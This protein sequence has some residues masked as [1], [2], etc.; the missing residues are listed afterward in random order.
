MED[1]EKEFKQL[2]EEKENNF[3]IAKAKFLLTSLIKI[4]KMKIGYIL[5]ETIIQVIGYVILYHFFGLWVVIGIYFTI[6][7]NNLYLIRRLNKKEFNWWKEIW[8]Y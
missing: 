7:S 8:K 1:A 3:R 4:N 2:L 5:L 6:W